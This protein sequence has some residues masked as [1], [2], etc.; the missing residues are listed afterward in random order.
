MGPRL[1]CSPGPA[2]N[3]SSPA[4]AGGVAAAFR[5]SGRPAAGPPLD[6]DAAHREYCGPRRIPRRT[7]GRN[8][9]DNPFARVRPAP[10][11]AG[12]QGAR[13]STCRNGG[14]GASLARAGRRLPGGPGGAPARRRAASSFSAAPRRSRSRLSAA[15]TFCQCLAGAAGC[16]GGVSG[17]CD[18][19]PRRRRAGGQPHLAPRHLQVG[20]ATR[21]RSRPAARGTLRRGRGAGRPAHFPLCRAAAAAVWRPRRGLLAAEAA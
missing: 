3:A 6:G 4:S 5:S 11:A 19:L 21:A 17:P 10:P 15:G 9:A 1:L 7:S 18:G 13:R 12:R 20:P 16:G 8:P 2:S 14:L